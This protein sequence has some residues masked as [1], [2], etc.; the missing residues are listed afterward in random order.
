MNVYFLVERLF[1][2]LW[3]KIL[4]DLEKKTLDLVITNTVIVYAKQGMKGGTTNMIIDT[5]T[6]VI[7]AENTIVKVRR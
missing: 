1:A 5:G 7:S 2:I 3:D 4:L 6:E